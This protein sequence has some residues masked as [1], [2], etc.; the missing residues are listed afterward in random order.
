MSLNTF[1]IARNIDVASVRGGEAGERDHGL[2]D[3]VIDIRIVR[4]CLNLRV[5]LE[6]VSKA[7]L[8]VGASLRDKVRI[9][10]GADGVH[11]AAVDR[12]L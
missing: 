10:A 2:K 8:F 11:E 6:P 5:T 9:T 3:L 7:K 1:R 4:G 12:P